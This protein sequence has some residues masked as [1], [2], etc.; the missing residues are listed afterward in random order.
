MSKKILTITT[1]LLVVL[2]VGFMSNSVMAAGVKNAVVADNTKEDSLKDGATKPT[3]SSPKEEISGTKQTLTITYDAAKLKIVDANPEIGR[4]GGY[5]W[6]GVKV[7]A[8]TGAIGCTEDDGTKYSATVNGYSTE[9]S[10]FAFDQYFA[11]SEE[12]LQDAVANGKDITYKKSYVWDY[13]KNVDVSNIT[14]TTLVVQI[15]ASGVELYPKEESGEVLWDKSE[16]EKESLMKKLNDL[17]EQVKENTDKTAAV[18]KALKEAQELL[19]NQSATLKELQ[20]SYD[21]LVK[22]LNE[23]SDNTEAAKDASSKEDVSEVDDTPKTGLN[24]YLGAVTGVLAISSIALV[25][26]KKIEE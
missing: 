12:K 25:A 26:M 15:K 3:T 14:E 2:L 9:D 13:N 20:K 17:T 21:A 1:L 5:S 16:Y 24:S 8:P 7:T 19:K 10:G 6:V 23:S 18:E 22:L 4:E 11:V